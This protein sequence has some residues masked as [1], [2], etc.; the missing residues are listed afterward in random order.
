MQT[1]RGLPACRFDWNPHHA[2]SLLAAVI[3]AGTSDDARDDDGALESAWEEGGRIKKERLRVERKLR[4]C[5][6][7][8]WVVMEEKQQL[9]SLLYQRRKRDTR[10]FSPLAC[11]HFFE[12]CLFPGSQFFQARIKQVSFQ[13]R[14]SVLN[15]SPSLTPNVF[16]RLYGIFHCPK[17]TL[18]I[19]SLFVWVMARRC[20]HHTGRES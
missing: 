19:C 6:V 7:D 20:C 4:G 5:Q 18:F 11:F 13:S 16:L 17:K 2:A 14:C 3:S 15:V 8:S 9:A 12:N 1:Y 10:L